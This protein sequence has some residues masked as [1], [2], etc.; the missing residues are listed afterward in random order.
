MPI[1]VAPFAYAKVLKNVAKLGSTNPALRMGIKKAGP[2]V[3]DNGE[4][5]LLTE[6]FFTHIHHQVTL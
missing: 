5:D 6:K 1:E 3:T 2:V 4:R